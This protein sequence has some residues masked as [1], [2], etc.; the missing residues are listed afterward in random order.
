MSGE[1][2]RVA[3]N[4]FNRGANKVSTRKTSNSD[5][6]S[7]TTE[8]QPADKF[9]SGHDINP[10]TMDKI[11]EST[12]KYFTTGNKVKAL[13]DEQVTPDRNDDEIFHNIKNLIRGARKSV[14]VEMFSL[15]RKSIIEA[16]TDEAKNGK[17][18]QVILH[19]PSGRFAET[20]QE[21][22]D[23][24]RDGGVDVQLYPVNKAEDSDIPFNQLNHVKLMIV[25]GKKAIIGGMNWGERSSN[26][27][28][29]DVMVEGPAVS[30]MGWHFR[31]DWQKSGGDVKDLPYIGKNEPLKDGTAMVN[32]ITTGLEDNDK[33]IKW[34]VNRAIRNAKKSINAQLYVLTD[35]QVVQNMVDAKNRGVDVKVMLEPLSI[36]G[37]AV[38]E[39]AASQLKDAG[40]EVRWFKGNPE[41][42][43]K[44]HSKMATFDDDQAIV[45]SANWT[46]SGLNVNREAGVEILSREVNR[47]LELMFMD[48]WENRTTEE[49]VY[50]SRSQ[51][52]GDAGDD[53]ETADV[54]RAKSWTINDGL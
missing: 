16:L 51:D 2:N 37:Y 25:D 5:K 35:R 19:P 41:T 18:V 40:I 15:N 21:A 31:K 50:M 24:L 11:P 30:K 13:F 42:R 20:A 3:G 6:S 9:V 22:L 4:S 26:N 54:Q 10:D 14:Q 46:Y 53:D 32:F 47:D 29:V 45:G 39:R 17:K 33:S 44:Q 34:S 1:I 48:D 8:Q 7:K 12:R 36:K 27:R 28:D 49:P 23:K 43:Q 52:P 38:N